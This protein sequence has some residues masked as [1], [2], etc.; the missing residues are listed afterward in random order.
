MRAGGKK[1]VS[2]DSAHHCCPSECA[3]RID[4]M[5][6]CPASSLLNDQT[7]ALRAMR[8]ATIDIE[9]RLDEQSRAG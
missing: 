9:R 7:C 4:A 2:Q 5:H 1:N 3:A 8:Q 6:A